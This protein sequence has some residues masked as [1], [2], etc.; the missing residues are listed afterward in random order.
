M[1]IY[2]FILGSCM[3][4]VLM[5]TSVLP[6]AAVTFYGSPLRVTN[7]S[8]PEGYVGQQY[9]ITWTATGGRAP[10]FWSFVSTDVAG[11]AM[12]S[13]DGTMTVLDP[14][15]GTWHITMKVTD[16]DGNEATAWF[17]WSVI[18]QP[19]SSSTFQINPPAFNFYYTLGGAL[20]T[21][22]SG[23]YYNVSGSRV[24]YHI[25]IP[26]QPSWINDNWT[27]DLIWLDPGTPAGIGASVKIDNL[28]GNSTDRGFS[29]FAGERTN[30]F[31]CLCRGHTSAQRRASPGGDKYH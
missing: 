13:N 11:L 25:G 26:N 19:S 10:Y 31:K 5:L 12:N 30:Y 2:K 24:Y 28:S 23:Q 1:K 18:E 14:P 21:M 16:A 4:L 9:D 6:A 15:A 7:Q 22:Q 29:G 27:T 17:T 8:M 20:P 3:G